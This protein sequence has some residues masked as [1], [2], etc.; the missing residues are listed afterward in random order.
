MLI[1]F[2]AVLGKLNPFQLLMLALV[3]TAVFIFNEHLGYKVM[4]VLDVG[5]KI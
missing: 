3:E 1:S 2:G 4:G 5:E